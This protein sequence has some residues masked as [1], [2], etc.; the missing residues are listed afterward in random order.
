MDIKIFGSG[1][2]KFAGKKT[3]VHGIVRF[4]PSY[5]VGQTKREFLNFGLTSDPYR[6]KNH[7]NH[8]LSQNPDPSSHKDSYLRPLSLDP[9]T[10]F[11]FSQFRGFHG[12]SPQDETY[13]DKKIQQKIEWFV[14]NR[15]K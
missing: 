13:V 12:L 15:M 7:K 8:L 10:S 11:D 2:R 6:G 14:K 4:H 9:K 3:L 1:S 5:L